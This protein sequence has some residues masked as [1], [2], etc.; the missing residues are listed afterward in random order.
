M[1]KLETAT[2]A[3]RDSICR[4][5]T[6]SKAEKDANYKGQGKIEMT[7]IECQIRGKHL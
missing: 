1:Q 2:V 7:F 3:A 6:R 4:V 5:P